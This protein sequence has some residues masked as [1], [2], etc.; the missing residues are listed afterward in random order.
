MAAFD[1]LPPTARKALADATFDYAVQPILTKW[2][3]GHP[4]M[5]TGEQIAQM[6]A[7]WDAKA[8][9]KSAKKRARQ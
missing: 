2:R 6:I 8:L 7:Q 5:R 1:K 9:A 3:K 4:A